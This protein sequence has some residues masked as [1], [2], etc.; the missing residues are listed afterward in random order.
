[1]ADVVVGI[2]DSAVNQ[3]EFLSGKDVVNCVNCALLNVKVQT[4]SQELKSV[5]QI[6]ALLQEDMNTLKKEF[7][8]DDMSGNMGLMNI[9]KYEEGTFSFVKSKS[10]TK[11]NVDFHKKMSLNLKKSSPSTIRTANPFEVLYNLDEDVPQEELGGKRLPIQ[12]H[13]DNSDHRNQQPLIND[14]TYAITVIIKGL[15]SVATNKKNIN[16]NLKVVLNKTKDVKS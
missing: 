12:F 11:A 9:H 3:Y 16:K 6:I 5:R 10:L 15:T 2:D 14:L 7:M 1:M 13:T 4:V 8:Q